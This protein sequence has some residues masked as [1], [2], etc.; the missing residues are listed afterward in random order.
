MAWSDGAVDM[1]GKVAHATATRDVLE[2]T[3]NPLKTRSCGHFNHFGL[4]SIV[5]L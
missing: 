2:H 5:S 1:R 3:L 4:N